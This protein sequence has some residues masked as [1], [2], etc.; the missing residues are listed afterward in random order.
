MPKMVNTEEQFVAV[1]GREKQA[2][3]GRRLSHG[4]DQRRHRLTHCDCA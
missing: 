3:G 1:C 4:W 2:R